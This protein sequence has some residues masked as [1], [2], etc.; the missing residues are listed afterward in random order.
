MK[1]DN[2]NSYL[3]F[4]HA[5]IEN[6]SLKKHSDKKLVLPVSYK[7]DVTSTNFTFIRRSFQFVYNTILLTN[8]IIWFSETVLT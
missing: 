4:F 7:L 5:D 1:N 8:N 2:V 3:S 6:L